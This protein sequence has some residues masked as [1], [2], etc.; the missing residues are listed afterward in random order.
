MTVGASQVVTYCAPKERDNSSIFLTSCRVGKTCQSLLTLC[1]PGCLIKRWTQ[2]DHAL[3]WYDLLVYEPSKPGF[4]SASSVCLQF[5]LFKKFSFLIDLSLPPPR[6]FSYFS[7]S[8]RDAWET[9]SEQEQASGSGNELIT[10]KLNVNLRR[11]Y[12]LTL[13]ASWLILVNREEVS[14]GNSQNR[15]LNLP[16]WPSHSEIN[17]A[18]PRFEIFP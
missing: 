7:F 4:I 18:K 2:S 12:R 11:H 17:G 10:S 14:E 3:C 1:R 6:A 15:K 8:A 9:K 5:F 16:C 13:A